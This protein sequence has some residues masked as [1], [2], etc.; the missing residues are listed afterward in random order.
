MDSALLVTGYSAEA[1]SALSQ[2]GL[3]GPQLEQRG[4]T[5]VRGGAYQLAYSLTEREL[6]SSA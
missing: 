5:G 2:S 1:V 6:S 3:G 4:A